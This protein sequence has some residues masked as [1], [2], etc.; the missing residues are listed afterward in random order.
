M[1]ENSENRTESSTSANKQSKD[2]EKGPEP[3]TSNTEAAIN[4][5]REEEKKEI[6][7]YLVS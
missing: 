7:P 2:I 6:D 4:S 1:S 3:E 5:N